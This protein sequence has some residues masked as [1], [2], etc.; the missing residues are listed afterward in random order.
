MKK[1]VDYLEQGRPHARSSP[2]WPSS[3]GPRSRTRSR[4][5]RA[6]SARPTHILDRRGHGLHVPQGPGPRRRQVARRG[7]P[8]ARSRPCILD[9]A[10]DQGGRA[11]TCRSTT[12]WP[13]PPEAGAATRDR[14]DPPLPRGHDGR[15]HRAQ[16]RRGLCRR[17]SPGPRRSSG[18]VPW[19]S[20][21]STRF[22]EGTIGMAQAVAASGAVSIVGGGDSIAAVK[23]AGVRDKI[24]H[25]STGGGASLEY[26]AYETLPGIDRP[27][28]VDGRPAS[29]PVRRGQLEDEP[30]LGPRRPGTWLR[31]SLAAAPELGDGRLVLVPPFTALGAGRRRLVAGSAVALGAQDLY[32]EDQGAFTGEV[33]G[34][35]LKDAGCAY[36][37]VGHSETP[38]A[39]RRDRRDGQPQGPGR[40]QGGPGPDRLR[41]RD[42]S[43]ERDAGRTLERVDDQLAA[44]GWPGSPGRT[45]GGRSS[46]TSPSG[47]SA[48]AGRPRRNRPRR[49]TPTSGPACEKPMEMTPP[50]VL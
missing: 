46:P 31:R 5:S 27:G 15:R 43:G 4:S 39:L 44:W 14:R 49:S 16:D 34:P 24:S 47:P 45:W 32:W 35:M 2:T 8:E 29:G 42:R 40:P 41:R 6:F 28:K 19:A 21:R 48:Q 37:L 10:A 38:P 7:R 25:I 11:S 33:S 18:T 17:S 13:R 1:E 26:I 36:V 12:S 3:A 30:D 22:A 23:K 9:K 50:L 20:S